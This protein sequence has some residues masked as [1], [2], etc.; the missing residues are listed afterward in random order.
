MPRQH[1]TPG[2]DPVPIVQG[3]GWAS[4][5]VWTG[6]EN[7]APPRFDPRTVQPVGSRYTDYA[8]KTLISTAILF[9]QL[10]LLNNAL[11][12]SGFKI[13]ICQALLIPPT[14]R[15]AHLAFFNFITS[16]LLA[17]GDGRHTN[18]KDPH[19]VIDTNLLSLPQTTTYFLSPELCFQT[20]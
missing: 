18:H 14:K 12:S 5:S 6:A 4:G 16:I 17:V 2:K 10:L 11:F 15:P 3:A 13:N 19:Y 1:L 20:P 8:R 9:H 7:L